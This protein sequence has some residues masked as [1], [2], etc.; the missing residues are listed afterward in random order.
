MYSQTRMK[1]LVTQAP[2]ASVLQNIKFQN[3]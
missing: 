1:Q 2:S 3:I